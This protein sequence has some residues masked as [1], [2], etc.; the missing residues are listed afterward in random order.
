MTTQ[1]AELTLNDVF[2]EFLDYKRKYV[3][4]STIA[5]YQNMY[6]SYLKD[7]FSEMKLN[8][9]NQKIVQNYL[10][11]NPY[12]LSKHTLSDSVAKIKTVLDWAYEKDLISTHPSTWKHLKYPEIMVE[13]KKT[14]LT[15]NEYNNLVTICQEIINLGYDESISMFRRNRINRGQYCA[16]VLGIMIAIFTGMRIGELS[17]LQWENVD[18]KNN[19]IKVRATVERIYIDG[20][21]KV[22]VGSPKSRTS[23]RDIPIHNTLK[24]C[25]TRYQRYFNIDDKCYLLSAENKYL[26]PRTYR[27]WYARFLERHGLP[28]M[29]FHGL[30]HTFC[31]V[32]QEQGVNASI[33][34]EFMGHA[35]LNTL[36][37]YTHISAEKKQL[38]I[39][40]NV[41]INSNTYVQNCQSANNV[42]MNMFMQL[43]IQ[44]MNTQNKI[45][46]QQSKILEMLEKKVK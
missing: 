27:S 11:E 2:D 38:A 40:G 10:D 25:L 3:K 36:P 43:M 7:Y 15:N 16:K 14:V 35:N 24:E 46:E 6:K 29:K 30:R 1:I 22:I 19:I 34:A 28:Y 12:K 33:V 21:T 31:S 9:I 13:K 37:T 18:F 32:M 42:D 39:N 41:N 17:G 44:Q 8:D 26:E 5:N 45:L 20:G 4:L 23:V